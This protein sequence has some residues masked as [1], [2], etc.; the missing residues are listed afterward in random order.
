MDINNLKDFNDYIDLLVTDWDGVQD[1][2]DFCHEQADGSEYVIYYANAWDLVNMIRFTDRSLLDDAE[3]ALENIELNDSLDTTMCLL[4][5][6][7]IYQ[8]LSLAVQEK[9]GA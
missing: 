9:E 3:L 2:H 6:E 1:L 5:Y 7:I 4:A 8:S